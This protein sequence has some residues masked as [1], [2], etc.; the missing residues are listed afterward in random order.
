MSRKKRKRKDLKLGEVYTDRVIRISG[1]G[2]G[3]I[4][5]KGSYLNLG[6]INSEYVGDL[7]Q[8]EFLGGNNAKLVGKQSDNPIKEKLSDNKN[9]LLNGNM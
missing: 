3:L 6:P 1:N 7:V 2:N 5:L 4:D 8:Y 9:D